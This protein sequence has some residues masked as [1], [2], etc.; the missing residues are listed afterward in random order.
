MPAIDKSRLK[1]ARRSFVTR[2]VALEQAT[3]LDLNRTPVAGDICLARIDN[4]GHHSRLELINGRRCTLYRGDEVILAFA[5]RYATDQ[6][7]SVVPENLGPC[8]MVASG[9]IASKVLTQHAGARRA[10]QITPLGILCRED[11]RA[12]N[13]SDEALSVA[14]PLSRRQPELITVVGTGMNAGKTRAMN[15]LVRSFNRYGLRTAAIK[16]T[17]TGS[18][19]DYWHYLDAGACAAADFTDAGHASTVNLTQE[20]LEKI[21]ASLVSACSDCDVIVAEI[22]DGL[23]QRET[24]ILLES[25]ML[26][27]MT[28]SIVLA[29]S[30][31]LAAMGG[32]RQLT[33]MRLQPAIVTG[34]ITKSSLMMREFERFEKTPVLDTVQFSEDERVIPMILRPA[35][36]V[37]NAGQKGWQSHAT[38]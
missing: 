3:R 9:G 26:R 30:D 8:Q 20:E 23:L 11:G 24:R 14:T 17:G 6:F 13:T 16:I 35:L 29:A 38:G 19:R 28:T 18:G 25:A 10:T 22:A 4:L 33:E 12:L 21:L 1:G 34:T 15:E 5:H 27:S 32:L 31:P 7:E 36:W 37:D 2:R